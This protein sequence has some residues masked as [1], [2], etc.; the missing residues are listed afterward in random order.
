[1]ETKKENS[2]LKTGAIE[3]KKVQAVYHLKKILAKGGQGEPIISFEEKVRSQEDQGKYPLYAK[4]W[5][6]PRK[7]KKGRYHVERSSSAF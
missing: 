4:G 1:M 5:Y 6:E 3:E 2:R 7:K